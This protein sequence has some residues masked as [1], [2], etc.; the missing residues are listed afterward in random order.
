MAQKILMV[1]VYLLLGFN[2][3][4][5]IYDTDAEL[6]YLKGQKSGLNQCDEILDRLLNVAP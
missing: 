2:G 3:G 5:Y 4:K 1:I 6:E